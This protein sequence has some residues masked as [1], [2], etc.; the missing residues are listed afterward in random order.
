M[1]DTRAQN[2]TGCRPAQR[3]VRLVDCGQQ[4]DIGQSVAL[5]KPVSAID[6][7]PYPPAGFITANQSRHLGPAHASHLLDIPPQQTARGLT[8]SRVLLFTEHPLYPAVHLFALL[9]RKLDCF[10]GFYKPANL[11]QT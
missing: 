6:F 11:L 3:L 10:A 1:A 2:T 9:P 8:L 4:L 7:A 5:G